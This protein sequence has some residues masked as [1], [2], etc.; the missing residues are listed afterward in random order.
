MFVNHLPLLLMAAAMMPYL[1]GGLRL[2]HLVVPSFAFLAFCTAFHPSKRQHAPTALG[3]LALAMGVAATLVGSLQSDQTGRDASP[4]AMSIR[5]WMPM[6]MLALFPWLLRKVNEPLLRSARAIVAL[7]FVA[8]LCSLASVFFEVSGLLA[9]WV[10]LE[11]DAVWAQAL[12]VGR[13]TGIFNQPLEAGVFFSVALFAVLYLFKVRP[14]ARIFNAVGL[15]VILLGGLL[16]LSKNFT[17]LGLGLSFFLAV[18]IRLVTLGTALTL[19]VGALI[20][21]VLLVLQLNAAYADSLIELFH[22]GGLLL[23]LTAGRLGAADTEVTQL[24]SQLSDRG[25]W[26]LGFGLGSQLPLDNGYLEFFYQGG[27]FSLS[28]YLVFIAALTWCALQRR[29]CIEGRLLLVLAVFI[30]TASFGGPVITASR[31]SVALMLLA[32]ACI[33]SMR[34]RQPSHFMTSQKGTLQWTAP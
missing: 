11:D 21:I 12:A 7:G 30:V 34:W 27:I 32:S 3:V 1:P 18:S 5:L 24:L 2:E 17:I 15:S 26:V 16:S 14:Q 28:G 25:Q 9:F 8:G 29:S 20:A 22:D 10:R 19:G 31:A 6:L 4:L 13:F 23:A 33:V